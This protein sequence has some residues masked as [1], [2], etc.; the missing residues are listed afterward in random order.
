[1]SNLQG[2][3][4]LITGSA[5]G[6]GK[7]TALR[8]AEQG[9]RVVINDIVPEKVEQTVAEFKTKGFDVLGKVADICNYESVNEMVKS[10]V[11]TFGSLDILVNNA[12]MEKA[13]AI[14][15]LSRKRLGYHH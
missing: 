6:M 13:G 15:N 14:R 10:A 5:S 2:K 12:G 4:A 7:K 3:V 11:E 9:V 8:L 1:M